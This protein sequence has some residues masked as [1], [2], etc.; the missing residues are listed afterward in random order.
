MFLDKWNR[1]S[2]SFKMKKAEN[3]M[4]K[5]WI[6]K[7]LS[8][9][10]VPEKPFGARHVAFIITWDIITV[11]DVFSIQGLDF[12]TFITKPQVQLVCLMHTILSF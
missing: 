6:Q 12:Q 3:K 10:Y 5:T 1:V 8:L 2:K 7:A 11:N 9:P 4:Y